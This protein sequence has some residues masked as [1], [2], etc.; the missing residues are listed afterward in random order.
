MSSNLKFI[1][2]SYVSNPAFDIYVK[3]NIY[4]KH[5]SYITKKVGKE[6]NEKTLRKTSNALPLVEM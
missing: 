6:S 5:T 1:A 4:V 2:G 3:H